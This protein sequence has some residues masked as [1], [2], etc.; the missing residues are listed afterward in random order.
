MREI[1]VI[2]G[3]AAGL[4]AAV[5]A[6]RAGAH[7]TLLEA[8]KRVGK[9]ILA[10]G[11]GRCNWTNAHVAAQAYSQPEF[12]GAALRAC[13][14]ERVWAWFDEMGL[15]AFEEPDGRRYPISNKASSV[16]DVLRFRIAE[17]PVEVLVSAT[18]S[19]VRRADGH[20]RVKLDGGRGMRFDAVI[21]ACGGRV[22]AG[23]LPEGHR[24]VSRRPRLCPIETE[25]EPLRGLDKVRARAEVTLSRGGRVVACECGEVQFRSS[26]VSGICVFDLS[27]LAR[28]GDELRIDFL[29]GTSRSQLAEQ[30]ALRRE[31]FPHR[32]AEQLLAGMVL[33]AVARA[34]LR[35][36]RVDPG[37]PPAEAQVEDIA[38]ALAGFTLHVRGFDGRLAQV[39]Q[40]GVALDQVDP[41]TM[42]SRREAGLHIVGEALDVDGPCGGFNLHW[43]WTSGLLAGAAAAR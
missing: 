31:R 15:V 14:P 43:A 1:A 16:L 4:V 8:G 3:G 5:E 33:P 6:A 38:R 10:S 28:I 24:I 30:V 34:A 18:V 41:D 40:G 36:A 37:R 12:V 21:V 17:L 42:E 13:P 20:L 23:L 26:G 39:S 19:E 25:R 29:P 2:G 7:V 32:D 35:Q 27:R 22:P 9:T 11:N